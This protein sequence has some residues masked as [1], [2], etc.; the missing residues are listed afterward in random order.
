[1]YIKYFFLLPNFGADMLWYNENEFRVQERSC[2]Y[3][4]N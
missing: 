2:L 3:V 4:Y 1:M